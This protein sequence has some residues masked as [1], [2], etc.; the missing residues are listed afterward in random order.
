MLSTGGSG[1]ARRQRP[2]WPAGR[3]AFPPSRLSRFPPGRRARSG[4]QVS[5]PGPLGARPGA[6]GGTAGS[7]GRQGGEFG[8]RNVRSRSKC[9]FRLCPAGGAPWPG[10][11]RCLSGCETGDPVR[12]GACSL[13]EVVRVG[14]AGRRAAAACSSRPGPPGLEGTLAGREPRPRRGSEWTRPAE[15]PG[16]PRG[17]R[18]SCPY[19]Q[20]PECQNAAAKSL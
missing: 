12:F 1:S 9:L 13:R 15:G 8:C 2:C 20:V 19:A 10:C 11:Q 3:G 18:G 5:A 4:A 16:S 17:R 7:K 6:G 14:P